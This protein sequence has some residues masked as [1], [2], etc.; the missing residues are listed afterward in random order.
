M[1]EN[2][3][4]GGKGDDVIVG[5][6][7]EGSKFYGD[8]DDDKITLN[9]TAA[10]MAAGGDGDD[11]IVSNAAVATGTKG[12]TISGG[13]GTDKIEV[14]GT[15]TKAIGDDYGSEKFA[16]T[17]TYASAAEFISD[18]KV[19][20]SIIIDDGKSATAEVS[21]K[22][23]I[24]TASDFSRVGIGATDG[25]RDAVEGLIIKTVGVTDVGSISLSK[26]A[27]ETLLGIDASSATATTTINAALVDNG[28]LLA[29]GKGVN[30]I[31]GGDGDDVVTGGAA[32]DV[33]KSGKGDDRINTGAGDDTIDGGD[34]DDTIVMGKFFDEGKSITAGLGTDT[35]SFEFT[36]K[37]QAA[38]NKIEDADFEAIEFT[39]GASAEITL[40]KDTVGSAKSMTIGMEKPATTAKTLKVIAAAEVDEAATATLQLKLTAP[41]P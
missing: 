36:N 30:K 26:E 27:G 18:N 37:T 28:M 6:A 34:G 5:A 29:G 12:H 11:T 17:L 25:T 40:D 14:T 35:L 1:G 8:K 20:D 24:T 7:D 33:L 39:D 38:L 23:S 16:T 41:S 10:S 13:A 32:D 21:E 3:V 22:L 4:Y 31:T 15:T 19:V 2:T 9:S